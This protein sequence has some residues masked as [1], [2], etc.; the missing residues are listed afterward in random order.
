MKYNNKIKLLLT[1]LLTVI[2]C[3]VFVGCDN[4][5]EESLSTN[6]NNTETTQNIETSNT[7][8]TSSTQETENA[9]ETA[10]TLETENNEPYQIKVDDYALVKNEN[11]CCL[12]F[13]DISKY[14]NSSSGA[15]MVGDI[16]FHT[17]KDFKDTVTNGL[18]SDDAKVVVASFPR[19]A[20]GSIQTCDFNNLYE[21][22]LPQGSQT[23][24]LRW[25]GDYY[26]FEIIMDDVYNGYFTVCTE[27]YYIRQYEFWYEN[28][29]NKDTITVTETE[30]IDGK[31]IIHYKTGM[32]TIK[33]ERYTLQS[34]NKTIIVDKKFIVKGDP[35]LNP[36]DTVPS[37]IRLYCEEDGRYYIMN[38][39]TVYEDPTDEWLLQ[40][41][42]KRYVEND[43]E[44]M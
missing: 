38:I 34:G 11:G 36:S 39:D 2:L 8:E 6:D 42:I 18:L 27:E 13:D 3:F 12:M 1:V 15:I 26:A 29:L 4:S 24:E 43:H 33:L 21:P 35:T 25:G 14:K 31:V 22:I 10:I 16:G 20:D 41:G 23:P 37:N 9:E 44:V 7:E 17:I 19:N 40:F 28:I 32:A 30:E 5:E